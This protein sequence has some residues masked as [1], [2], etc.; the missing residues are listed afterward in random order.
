M[1]SR[2]A[3][4][5]LALPVLVFHGR[6]LFTADGAMPWDLRNYHLP[7]VT[8]MADAIAEGEFPYWEPYSYCGRPLAA[9]PQA[10]V[11]YPTVALAAAF[12]RE[13]LLDRLEWNVALHVWLA[14]WL[15]FRL[16]RRWEFSP[17]G[18]LCAALIY[19]LGG[20]FASQVQHMGSMMAAAWLPLAWEGARFGSF[21]RVA[22]AVFFAALAGFTPM[23]LVLIVSTL[24]WSWRA[25]TGVVAAL[26][27]AAFQMGPA[28]DLLQESVAKYR[29]D[30]M[31][32]G[33]G[34][35]WQSLVSLV[36][37]NAYGIFDLDT[38]RQPLELTFLYVFCG[39]L[40]LTLAVW[41]AGQQ[42]KLAIFAG[43]FGL[44]ML[45]QTTPVG[46]GLFAALP[47]FVQRSFY[48]YP[49]LAPFSLCV[50]LL[51]GSA[52]RRYG[53]W[54]AAV[55]AVELVAVGSG[56]PM[57]TQ[58]LKRE[59]GVDARQI[60]GSAE[61]LAAVRRWAGEGRIDTIGDSALWSSGAP[62]SRV[63]S[64][65]GY[66]PL[67][68]EH[69]IQVRL[70]MAKG[71]RWG[72]FYQ[73]ERPDEEALR[74]LAVRAIV[75][76]RPVDWPVL[77][78]AQEIPGRLIYRVKNPSVRIEWP[79]EIQVLNDSRHEIRV[80][81]R[82]DQAADLLVRD[83]FTLGWRASVDGK[84]VSLV[85]ALGA[86]RSVNVPAGGHEVVMEIDGWRFWRWSLV[87]LAMLILCRWL[88][89]W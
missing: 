67:A 7:L 55:L 74:A 25:W 78:L 82:H 69:L 64:A 31:G 62:V 47:V 21:W 34:L 39:W 68:L 20:F 16:A 77:E 71:A 83:A 1:S 13:G 37:P 72:A 79:G 8:A 61:S 52:V 89:V 26:G 15:A 35:P 56:R 63:R 36:W 53:W 84:P 10:A 48:W 14:A 30:W 50:A 85:R 23:T 19:S 3:A 5:L 43:L 65:N 86:F 59:P 81:V 87:S 18:A 58:S 22:T 75:T 76:R 11:F 46:V 6:A 24:C 66:D 49:F 45:G 32:S 54:V 88:S 40:G 70:K 2:W 44:L 33:G 28:Y 41:G 12:G 17:A 27:L 51:A 9:N 38:Y 42:R 57:N 60:D 73:V 80:R 4:L 29:T